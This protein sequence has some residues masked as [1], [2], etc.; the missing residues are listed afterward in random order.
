MIASPVRPVLLGEAPN[1]RAPF[2]SPLDGRLELRLARTMGWEDA[3]AY[4]ELV[5]RFEPLNAI[6]NAD[7]ADPWDPR[8]A[9]QRWIRFYRGRI[10]ARTQP[11]VVVALGRRA[12]DAIGAKGRDLYDWRDGILYSSV[13]VPHPSGL[14]RVWNDP[15]TEDRVRQA[16][17]E[18][19][20]RSASRAGA[21]A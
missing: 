8:L 14:N 10:M 11:T 19:I 3:R 5:Q 6:E 1:P 2:G 17:T 21:A 18:A 4:D 15:E 9:S 7:D 20:R 12:G 16:L 13:V